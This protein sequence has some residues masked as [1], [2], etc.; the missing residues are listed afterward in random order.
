[1]SWE[2]QQRLLAHQLLLQLLPAAVDGLKEQQAALLLSTV[3]HEAG[4]AASGPAAYV[5]MDRT[6]RALLAAAPAAA[7][8]QAL[9][10]AAALQ[11]E[12]LEAGNGSAPADGGRLAVLSAAQLCAVLCMCRSLLAALAAQLGQ[13]SLQQL[14]APGCEGALQQLAVVP[15]QGLVLRGPDSGN[16]L[17]GASPEAAG[18]QRQLFWQGSA[19]SLAFSAEDQQGAERFLA[20]WRQATTGAAQ[21]AAL[22]SAL[23]AVPLF[24]QQGGAGA[25]PF[26]PMP[27]ASLMPRLMQ[28]GWLGGVCCCAGPCC[29][30]HAWLNG[31]GA[32][33]PPP[34]CSA[35]PLV[36]AHGAAT[37]PATSSHLC[38]CAPCCCAGRRRLL[39]QRLPRLQRQQQA[40]AAAA[41][42]VPPHAPD[43]A[44]RQR[45]RGA[46]ARRGWP[47]EPA[48]LVAGALHAHMAR[49]LVGLHLGLPALHG[50]GPGVLP[51]RGMCCCPLHCALQATISQESAAE[52]P[53]GATLQMRG[54]VL[55]WLT[56]SEGGGGGG[57]GAPTSAVKSVD[58][59]LAEV[60]SALQAAE[61][62]MER[63]RSP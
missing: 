29:C 40:R 24:K 36:S 59:V 12:V 32:G 33:M 8:P 55:P 18:S 10:L 54:L 43:L 45:P 31:T 56:G 6:L 11:L 1:M 51:T 46:G 35:A 30:A 37:R 2:P 15:A 48:C 14:A 23:A 53:A 20:G 41:H 5:A 3:W 21:Q 16:G 44:L 49:S 62:A 34:P 27:L 13:P 39:R 58:E 42:H 17:D 26:Q 61:E 25:G 9:K 28:V 47:P 63:G 52:E 22:A 7:L 19:V 50:P 38:R 60:D 57:E 4:L